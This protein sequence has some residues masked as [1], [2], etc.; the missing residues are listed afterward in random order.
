MP[1]SLEW[2][3][4]ELTT[5]NWTSSP[6]RHELHSNAA[7]REQEKILLVALPDAIIHEYAVVIHALYASIANTRRRGNQRRD[8]L[9]PCA[10]GVCIS[11]PAM[12]R[13]GRFDAMASRAPVNGGALLVSTN[14]FQCRAIERHCT[15][16]MGRLESRLTPLDQFLLDRRASFGPE[17]KWRDTSGRER[18]AGSSMCKA[19]SSCSAERQSTRRQTPR[20]ERKAR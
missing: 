11:V 15:L 4:D 14:I 9:P 10:Q 19:T 16:R 20:R 18:R 1:S 12:M 2:R 7:Y 8:R 13:S 17:M 6:T 3:A 5:A